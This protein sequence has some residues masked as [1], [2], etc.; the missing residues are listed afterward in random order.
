MEVQ[1]RRDEPEQSSSAGFKA[2]ISLYSSYFWNRLTAILP[3]SDLNFLWKISNLYRRIARRKRRPYLPL[4]LPSSSLDSYVVL[5]QSSRVYDVLEEMMAR[6]LL[7]LHNVQKNLQFWQSRAEGTDYRRAYFMIF[8]RGPF[9]FVDGAVKFVRK[10]VV[11][12]SPMQHLFQ[13]AS[14]YMSERIAVLA[15]LRCS[16]ATFLAQIYVEVDRC[17]EELVKDPEKT[18]PSLLVIIDGLF[19][20]LE[21]SIGHLHAMRWSDSS[22]DGSYSFP[23]LFEKLPEVNQEGSQW[24]E[25]ELNDAINVV[26]KNLHKLD[27]YLSLMVA[28]HRKPK[29]VTLCWIRYTCGAVGLSVV[30]MWLLRHSSLMGSSDIDNW[31]REAKEATISFFEE[32]VE[33]PVL[34]IRDDLF[35]TFRKRDKGVM[36][37]EE[38]QLTVNSLHRMLRAFSE[39]TMGPRFLENASDQEMLE[40]VMARYEKEMVHPIHNLLSGE[41]ARALLIQVQKLKLDIEMAMLELDQILRAN[42]IN[43]AILAALPAFSL[44]II[45]VMLVRA[46]FKQDSKAEGRGRTARLQR[47]LLIVEVEKRIMQYQTYADQGREKDAQC[48]YGL[49]IYALDR[50]YHAAERQANETG[51]WQYLKQ[52]IIELGKPGLPTASKLIVTSRMERMYASLLP[53][54]K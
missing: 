19:L 6:T 50:L 3:S 54:L 33:Q 48:I 52:D 43:F 46:W 42:E 2:L 51:E 20:D 21:A 4:P 11:E 10:S 28:K 39:Q 24:T 25:C 37:N 47:R 53:P 8:E 40:I 32:H 27:S 18:L 16:L 31:I 17:G 41:L 5:K 22:V 30:S 13:S 49:M 26:Y 44:F 29:K 23:L 36:N 14:V 9:A 38:V 1:S 12:G 45:L 35:E 7:N 15:A 34:S